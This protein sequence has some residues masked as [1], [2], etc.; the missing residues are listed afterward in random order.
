MHPTGT[1]SPLDEDDR[2]FIMNRRI[3]A[4]FISLCLIAL[5]LL[6]TGKTI[7]IQAHMAMEDNAVNFAATS[8]ATGGWHTCA[9][10]TTGGVKCWGWNE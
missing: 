7:S 3:F 2:E 9:L 10:T 8:I 1:N 5:F 6:D 4:I